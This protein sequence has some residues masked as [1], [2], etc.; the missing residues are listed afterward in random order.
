MQQCRSLGHGVSER[1]QTYLNVMSRIGKS[2]EMASRLVAVRARN[3]K[4]YNYVNGCG[5]FFVGS[6][7]MF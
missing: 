7:G 6:V 3:G 4:E 5:S 2:T 1:S